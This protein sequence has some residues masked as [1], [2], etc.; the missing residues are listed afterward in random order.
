LKILVETHVDITNNKKF[1]STKVECL[2][3][4]EPRY[5]EE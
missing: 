3:A 5:L 2:E 4:F 1:E